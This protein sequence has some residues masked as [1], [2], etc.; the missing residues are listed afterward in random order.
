VNAVMF[1]FILAECVRYGIE[2][3][4]FRRGFAG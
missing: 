4:A 1:A 3:A 2:I